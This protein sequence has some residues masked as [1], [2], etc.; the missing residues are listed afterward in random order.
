MAFFGKVSMRVNTVWGIL[1]C[2]TVLALPAAADDKPEAAPP[3]SEPASPAAESAKTPKEASFAEP[4][5][6]RWG[7][8]AVTLAAWEPSVYGADYTVAAEATGGPT[9]AFSVLDIPNKSVIRNALAATWLLPHDSGGIRFSYDSIHNRS[10]LERL[11]PGT[12][13][14]IELEVDP[15]FAGVADDG[16]SDGILSEA[17]IK[18]RLF[19][20]EYA[21]TGFESSHAKATW[22]AG[23]HFVDHSRSLNAQYFALAPDL[24]PTIPPVEP[25]ISLAPRPDVAQL[26]SDFS[27]EG[28]G[29]GVDLEFAVH[30]RVAVTAGLSAGVVMGTL[31]TRTTSVT[32]TYF[33][34]GGPLGVGF[35]TIDQLRQGMD[36]PASV[37]FIEQLV[38]PVDVRQNSGTQAAEDFDAY[39]GVEGKV[40]HALRVYAQYRAM[41][42]VN[43]ASQLRVVLPVSS[44]IQSAAY[45]GLVLGLTYRF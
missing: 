37:G 6:H 14:F 5:L 42:F 22:H 26:R 40:T 9:N 21:H 43:V 44:S 13:Q 39:V 38:D 33:S 3:A 4:P 20:L 1:L 32:F 10:S 31:R 29:A 34:T 16:L 28:V 36:D 17:R 30:P 7:G 2:G 12:F 35:L 11:T 19:R 18:S 24:P 23:L 8:L 15:T 45:R 41:G 25:G 27:G